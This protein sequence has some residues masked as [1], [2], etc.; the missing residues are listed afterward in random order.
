MSARDDFPLTPRL[1]CDPHGQT[2]QAMAD[3]IDR[4]R[5]EVQE[6]REMQRQRDE[7]DAPD[8]LTD[9]RLADLASNVFAPAEVADMASELI[10]RRKHEAIRQTVNCPTCGAVRYIKPT[11]ERLRRGLAGVPLIPCPD[12][13]DGKIDM[14]RLLAVGAEA[15]HAPYVPPRHVDGRTLYPSPMDHLLHD[16]RQVRP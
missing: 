5:A 8:E 1:R 15:L 10:A 4:L 11:P 2:W 13:T 6:Y 7:R 3:K 14:A 16:L 9:Q 12:C